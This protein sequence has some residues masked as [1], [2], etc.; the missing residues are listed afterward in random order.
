MIESDSDDVTQDLRG[1]PIHKDDLRP[2]QPPERIGRYWIENVLGKG[3]FGIVYLARDEQLNRPV[4]VKVPHARLISKPEDAELYLAEARTVASLDHPCIVPVYDVGSSQD[5]PCYIVSKYIQ[6]SDL[7][8]RLKQK[9]LDYREAAEL[10]AA[11]S[12]ALHYA[13]KRGLVHR[14]VKPGNILLSADGKPYVVDFG[15]ALREESIGKGPEY[16][17]TPAYMSPEQ[18]RGEGHRV[19]GRSDI[20]SLGVVFYE[21]LAGRRPFRGDTQADLLE[22][23]TSYEARPLR[24]YDEKLP[25]ELD[26]ICQKAM[27]KRAS[28][29]YSSAHDMSEDL[30]SFLAEQTVIHGG[31]SP[32]RIAADASETHVSSDA[33]GLPRASAASSMPPNRDSSDKDPLKIVPKGLRSFDAHDADF[34]LELLPGPRDRQGLPDS[35]RFWKTRVE[36]TDPDNT[37]SVGL[38]YGPSGCGKSSLVKA[39]LLP[40]LSRDVI[41]VYIEA[42]PDETEARLLH[43]L[44]KRCPALEDDLSLKATLAA[45]RRGQGVPVGKKVLIVLDQFEQWLYA[46]KE[47]TNS[48][49]VQAL[50]QCDGG[51]VQCIV[52]VRDDF[53]L[54]ATRFMGELEVELRQ[55]QNTALADLFDLNHARQVL[56]AFG[57]A[58]G[59]LPEQTSDAAK[60]QQDF[61]KQS[62]AGLA[63]EGKVVCVRLALFAEM[64][65]SKE[66]T[67]ATLKEVGG[68]KGIGV[69]FLEE[70]FSSQAAHPQHRLHQ[71]AARAVLSALLPD[72]GSDIKGHMRSH[73]ELL[74]ASGY[75]NRPKDFD[76]LIRILDSEIRLITPTDPEGKASD[77]L[78]AMNAGTGQKYFQLTH[79]YLVHSL[80]EWLTRKQKETR[81]GRAELRLSDLSVTWNSKPE[82]RFLPSWW[83]NLDI[84]LFTDK[85]KWTETQRKMMSSAGRV[86]GIRSGI[87]ALLLVGAVIAVVSVRKV[88][89]NQR[90]R[91]LAQVQEKENVTRA[92]GLVASLLSADIGKVPAIVSE[93]QAY[94][95]WADPL[96]REENDK[97]PAT[98]S[99]KL[100]A[101]LALLPVDV[102]QVAFLYGRMLDAEPHEVPVIRDALA[103]HSDDLMEKLWAAAETPEKGSE[104]Q[105]LRAAAALAQYAPE[106][107][108]WANIQGS[109]G[110]D[111]VTVPAVHLALWMDSL[112]PVRRKLFPQLSTVYRDGTRRELERSLAT[113]ILAEYAT[114]QP[115]VLADLLM[116]A[117]IPQFAVIYSKFQA[118][119]E[120]GLPVLI[121]EID[122]KLPPELPSSDDGR[123]KLAKRQVNAAVALLKMNQPERVWPLLRHGP[124]PRVRSYLIHRLSPLAIDAGIIARQLEVEPDP[125]IRRALILCVGEFSESQLPMTERQALLPMLQEL[126][127]T[128][129]DSGLH[130]ASEWLLRTWGQDAWLTEVNDQWAKDVEHR[131]KRID[132]IKGK[133][134]GDKSSPPQWY[135]NGQGQTLVVIPGPVELTMGSPAT[136]VGRFAPDEPQFKKQINRTFAV[137]TKIV[138]QEQYLAFNKNWEAVRHAGTAV[139]ST[140]WYQSAAYLNWLSDQEGIPKEQWC[141]LPNKDGKYED[142]M[143]LAPN[144]LNLSGYRLPTAAEMEYAIRAG[145]VTSRYFGET[146]ELLPK[147]EWYQRN[148][149]NRRWPVGMLKPNDF[150][151]FD[152]NG[153]IATWCQGRFG[154]NQTPTD[155]DDHLEVSATVDREFRGGTYQSPSIQMRSAFRSG[156]LPTLKYYLLGFRV[157][158]TIEPLPRD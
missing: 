114:D 120:Q 40:R 65:K 13:H 155:D 59:R 127:R 19:D 50:R 45:L 39:G 31:A 158:R 128:E 51:R 87:V 60:Q 86:H 116:D 126:Y 21:L 97:A 58:F 94:R 66:W 121:A 140:N 46:R 102:G 77:S 145:S 7:A 122:R 107:E 26:R 64:M 117:D 70:T 9:R 5:C 115:T 74:E 119:R 147:Y 112:R 62:I 1:N 133:S 138:T 18:A 143:S 132:G 27:A 23:V 108:R 47:E 6:G 125:T 78:S 33:S 93:L 142:G 17:G 106:S 100:Y 63:E 88:L 2:A 41:P 134:T 144:F 146:E 96:L 103:P 10:I 30:R 118:H 75:G 8:T 44:R 48:D 25:R 141:Y 95:E 109:V 69:T 42:T 32:G 101:G 153:N 157:A 89:H 80:R 148:G 124:D 29:R 111:L 56:A 72:S 49:L 150:G 99:Q 28:E 22:R 98:S 152:S 84:R 35:I 11:V 156:T 36:E 81:Q 43:G 55:G 71:K 136:E 123:E 12:D 3:G 154:G 105:R 67:P 73:A 37:F 151:L 76:D 131:G 20:F 113:D 68:T 52:M 54:A 130:A 53:W 82:N 15:L 110:N 14:D 104:S 137:S 135:V 139:H 79:D 129:S 57:R 24:Q 85:K 91:T 90:T 61:L 4:A 149:Q 34:F 92:Q 16:A 83:E 38:I